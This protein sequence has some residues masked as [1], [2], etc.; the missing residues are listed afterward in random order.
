MT[1]GFALMTIG[2]ILSLSGWSNRSI[3]EV[4]QGFITP[5]GTGPGE[6]AFKA[7]S[8]E[9]LAGVQESVGGEGGGG[10]V[11]PQIGKKKSKNALQAVLEHPE[12]KP[13]VAGA[14]TTILSKFPG[15]SIGSTLRPGDTD[16]R[17]SEGRAAD[18]V[19]S[20]QEMN[21]AA[22]W[23]EKYMWA[24]LNEGIHNP[25]LSVDTNHKVPPSFWGAATWADHTDHIHVAV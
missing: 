3:A 11:V 13:G 22:R 18:L 8:K 24:S 9:V 23:I 15:L 5:N 7:G 12:L 14:V 4:L 25:G 6:S 1:Y 21:K 2:T 10:A 16:S 20:P 17:H 19:G